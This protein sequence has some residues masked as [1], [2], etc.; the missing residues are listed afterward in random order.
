MPNNSIQLWSPDTCGCVI[1]LAY[2][3]TLPPEQ[4][5]LTPVTEEEAEAIVD[6]RRQ[7]GEKGINPNRQPPA[8]LC[9][10]HAH[11]GHTPARLKQVKSENDS[12]NIAFGVAK[13]V[14]PELE[15]GEFKWSFDA[16]RKLQVEMPNRST[17]DRNRVRAAIN[18]RFGVNTVIVKD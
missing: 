11:L 10:A 17:G 5:V 8:K 12:K 2:D 15:V 9:A 3:D 18:S 7:A 1:H 16:Q 13:E 4:R 6:A 14:I